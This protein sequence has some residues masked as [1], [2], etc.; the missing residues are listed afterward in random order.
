VELLRRYS[1]LDTFQRSVLILTKSLVRS[2]NGAFHT[3]SPRHQAEPPEPFKLH[4]RLKPETVAEIV[5][6][7][8]AGEPSTALA[9]AFGISKGSVIRLLRDAGVTIRNQGLTND[10]VTKAAQLYTSGQS[11]AQIRSPANRPST[12][13]PD[14]RRKSPG[15]EATPPHAQHVRRK[16]RDPRWGRRRAYP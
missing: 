2:D 1:K 15:K 13:S 12:S 10:Q 5:A 4:Q 16:S 11:L 8:E 7:Y 9:I 6:R 14:G 3:P